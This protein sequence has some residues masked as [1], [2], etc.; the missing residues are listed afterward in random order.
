[1]E[2]LVREQAT[3]NKLMPT[4]II[5][6]GH[7]VSI[8]DDMFSDGQNSIELTVNYNNGQ[9]YVVVLSYEVERQLVPG[10]VGNFC[11]WSFHIKFSLQSTLGKGPVCL[12]ALEGSL[13]L[14]D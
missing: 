9:S 2:Q 12:T 8:S 1:M 3:Q 10:N 4:F 14:M 6:D 7:L 5:T 13:L 11:S